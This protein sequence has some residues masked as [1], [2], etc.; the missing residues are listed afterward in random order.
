VRAHALRR[1]MQARIARLNNSFIPNFNNAQSALQNALVPGAPNAQIT[2]LRAA[3]QAA[4]NARNIQLGRIMYDFRRI[5]A[6]NPNEPVP[7]EL[8]GRRV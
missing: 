2:T 8:V 5:R 1:D 6:I 3:V 4:R 7:P